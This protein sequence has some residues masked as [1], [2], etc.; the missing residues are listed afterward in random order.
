MG[1]MALVGR[2][3]KLSAQSAAPADPFARYETPGQCEQAAIRLNA[4]FWRD[5]RP[6][7]VVYA[8]KTDSV[9]APVL[10]AARACAARF[11]V[12]NVPEREL[13]N[14]VQL[15]LWTHQ[16]Q[17]A[18]AAID[19]LLAVEANK[20]VLDRG[21]TIEQLVLSLLNATPTQW[22]AAQKYLAQLDALGA[23]VATWR[24]FAH[25][26]VANFT[27][28]LNDRAATI[29]EAR[30]ALAAAH[31]MSRDDRTDWVYALLT[32]YKALAEPVARVSGG[33]AARALF[34][35]AE[36]DLLPLRPTGTREYAT[37]QRALTDARAPYTLFGTTGTT[38]GA[39]Q[40]YNADADAT[41]RPKPGKVSLLVFVS[42][43]CGGR[44]YPM[45]ATIRRLQAKYGSSG[46][47]VIFLASTHNYF[48]NHPMPSPAAESDSTGRYFVDFLKFDVPV[49]LEETHFSRLRDGRLQA[50]P[51]PN[52]TAYYRNRSGVLVD[53]RGIVTVVDT[54][55]PSRE[56]IWDA[57]I[58]RALQ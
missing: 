27:S 12:A 8:P 11:T 10:Q 58:Q 39:T 56:H 40:W 17:L 31:A 52:R 51:T 20:P 42:S 47:D 7:T 18:Q 33:S 16:G 32:A 44:C 14:L 13:L 36:T 57:E 1:L 30:S 45:Y 9:P 2:P 43:A 55:A 34:D 35:T 4:L 24:L 49:A 25:T 46:L 26:A 5:K 29:A 3:S 41:H 48:R 19:R 21:W 28:T 54:V 22:T 50:D 37:L 38:I 15:Y 6:D 53:R 23:P